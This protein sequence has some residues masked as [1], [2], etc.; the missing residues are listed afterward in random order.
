MLAVL[1]GDDGF[2]LVLMAAAMDKGNNDAYPNNF[3]I[4]FMM[5][6]EEEVNAIWQL[7]KNGGIQLDRAPGKIRNSFGFYFHFD[8]LMIEVGTL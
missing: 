6:S 7:L 2:E 8:K 4:G 5:G 1:H 3:H